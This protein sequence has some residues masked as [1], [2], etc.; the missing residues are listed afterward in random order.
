MFLSTLNIDGQS[1]DFDAPPYIIDVDEDNDSIDDEDMSAAVARGHGGDDDRPPSRPIGTGCQEEAE[2]PTG[3]AGEPA[4]WGPMT[5][6][7]T[8][9]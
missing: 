8:S 9:G 2:N 6:P 3:E 1:M 5:K 7:G 4:D